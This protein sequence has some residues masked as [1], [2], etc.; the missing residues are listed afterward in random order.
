MGQVAFSKDFNMLKS[1]QWNSEIKLIRDGMKI[2]GPLSPVPWLMRLGS[3]MPISTSRDFKALV[4]FRSK[5]LSDYVR[6]QV[7]VQA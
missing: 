1:A 7:M 6:T 4:C 2:L 3:S 5:S